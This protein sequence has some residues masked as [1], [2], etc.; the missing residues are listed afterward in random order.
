MRRTVLRV[1][2]RS[3]R[4]I[5]YTITSKSAGVHTV[6]ACLQPCVPFSR[7]TW[8]KDLVFTV[9]AVLRAAQAFLRPVHK[10]VV[11]L[12]VV[13]NEMDRV[14]HAQKGR[15]HQDWPR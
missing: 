5:P 6:C 4:L 3:A 2:H 13:V 15:V 8:F 7:R 10:T 9:H 14:A 12:V 11:Q 1:S